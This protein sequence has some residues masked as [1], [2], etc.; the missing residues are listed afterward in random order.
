[1]SRVITSAK[2]DFFASKSS[3]L[4]TSFLVIIGIVIGAVAHGPMY[5]MLFTMVFA[6][7]AA[8]SIFP[9]Y[10]R[11]HSEKLLGML[12]L[13]R[14]EMVLGRYCYALVIGIVYGVVAAVLGIV[15]GRIMNAALDS[16]TFWTT[17]MVAFIYFCFA[18]GI[19]YPIYL[20]FTFAKAYVFTML[21]MYI[22]AVAILFVSKKTN[23]VS[24]LQQTMNFFTNHLLLI[25]VC[26]ISCGLLLLGISAIIANLISAHKEI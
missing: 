11:S 10:E 23:I 9:T 3:L 21:P 6:V 14:S 17:L 1:M 2:L 19:S 12:P 13:K 26:G 5:T 4:L 18:V 8:G 7:T 15:L 16:F 25:P 22:L 20:K 24:D